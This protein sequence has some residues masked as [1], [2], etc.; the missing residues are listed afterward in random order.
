MRRAI[1]A[2]IAISVVV[3]ASVAALPGVLYWYGLSLIP[4][5]R[6]AIETGPVPDAAV[7][8]LWASLGG[9]GEP[10][11]EHLNPYSFLFAFSDAAQRRLL[12]RDASERLSTLAA[13]AIL[14]RG[15][16]IGGGM[17]PWHLARA[18]A[19]IWAGR[20]WSAREAIGAYLTQ[21]YFGNGFVGLESAAS[22][23]FGAQTEQLNEE[24]LAVL[25][26]AAHSPQRRDPWCHLEENLTA[27][28]QVLQRLGRTAAQPHAPT[29][30]APPNACTR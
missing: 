6:F 19:Y 23:Y 3:L 16:R 18:S 20:H 7:S 30:A 1:K 28:Q 21:A 13:H 26:V 22:G 15:T 17:G 4:N 12:E 25:L 2:A 9:S 14:P 10:A 5:E 8:T 11:L 24:Q 27:A 29:L